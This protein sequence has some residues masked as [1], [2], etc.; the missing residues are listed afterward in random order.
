MNNGICFAKAFAEVAVFN[1]GLILFPI[2]RKFLGVLRDH[3]PMKLWKWIPFNDNI[4]FHILAGHILMIAAIGHTIS[5]LINFS[6]YS[7]VDQ[8]AWDASPFSGHM[9]GPY[10]T[11]WDMMKSLPGWTG[12]A[13]LLIMV[14]A[15]P[16]A[17]FFRQKHFNT[18]W[19]THQLYLLWI[20]L[21][22][23]HGLAHIF[24]PA[25]AVWA[26][27]PGF[28]IYLG[29]R[30]QRVLCKEISRV[31]V[32][33][34][35]TYDNTTVLFVK[36]P[37]F[38]GFP[39][40]TPGCYA[41]LQISKIARFEWHP[42][43][44]SSA[45]GDKYLRFHIRRAGDWTT[46]LW[47]YVREREE[48]AEIAAQAYGDHEN[49]GTDFFRKSRQLAYSL[50]NL[51]FARFH[52]TVSGED[53]SDDEDDACKL[54]DPNTS[55]K[56]ISKF[57]ESEE[58]IDPTA[59]GAFFRSAL[60]NFSPVYIHGPFGAP[61]QDFL[62]YRVL[63]LVGAGIGVTPFASI[64]R[65]ILL[66]WRSHQCPECFHVNHRFTPQDFVQ[67]H[68]VTREHE[69]LSWFAQEMS[70]L[71]QMDV[72]GRLEMHHHLTG[73]KSNS[74]SM[75]H[76]LVTG[77]QTQVHSANRQDILSGIKGSK[78]LTHLGRPD[79][80]KYFGDLAAKYPRQTVGVFYCG[81]AVLQQV[82]QKTCEQSST[83][84]KTGG[85]KFVFYHE[86]F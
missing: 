3:T 51:H 57:V 62:R 67:F 21:F 72:E 14:I 34:A 23:V 43:T 66:N 46:A 75:A 49:R 12:H 83:S 71:A 63:V 15:Y 32:V 16:L 69:N 70:E 60:R 64:L 44:I 18:F 39:F 48:R 84:K 78:Q 56:T 22:M 25:H 77:F 4:A 85:T 68:W 86:N 6:R 55:L 59:R 19:L 47:E 80:K 81:P 50:N 11:Y 76:Q 65:H 10:P 52:L 20:V 17:A 28:V 35:E 53:S 2:C 58:D 24:A 7:K 13:M 74:D 54:D 26:A 30:L 73:V 38:A 40:S 82:L 9:N 1:G 42:F 79:W 61:T 41:S 31:E 27:L 45:P 29:E 5:H 33:H 37:R 36:K 8:A